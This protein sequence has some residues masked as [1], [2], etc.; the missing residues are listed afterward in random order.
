M[1]SLKSLST[2]VRSSLHRMVLRIWWRMVKR[3]CWKC[4]HRLIELGQENGAA[5]E[6]ID[7]AKDALYRAV[8]AA[9]AER[10]DARND[11]DQAQNPR[12]PRVNEGAEK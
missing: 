6:H 11:Q 3:E 12:E 8:A 4:A 2:F 9:E 1:K 5:Q 7:A 10:K